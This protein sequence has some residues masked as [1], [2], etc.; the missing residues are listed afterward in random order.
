MVSACGVHAGAWLAVF[1][2]TMWAT[3]RARHYQLALAMRLGCALPELMPVRGQRP[4]CGAAA[5]GAQHDEF[6]FHPGACRA[7]NRWGLWTA[8]HDAYQA[9]LVHVLRILGCA[10]ISCS[11]GAGNW[12]GAAG[13]RAGSRGYQRADVVMAHYF[14]P[15]R[16]M[17]LD[18]AV[19]DP[20]SGAALSASPSSATSSGIAAEQRA[21]KKV[22]KY[23]RLAAAVSSQ[24]RPAVVERFGACCDALVG[25]VSMLCGD[26]HRDALR[27]AD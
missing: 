15:G 9:M 19:T 23:G 21:E 26:R 12:F 20:A 4:P 16:H 27:D 11:V 18:C 24:F 3:A 17:F 22:A 14:G 1:P 6:G 5:C 8:R 10:A 2:M 7:G 13:V 25:L